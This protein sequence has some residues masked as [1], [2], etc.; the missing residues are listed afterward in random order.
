MMVRR[1]TD[2]LRSLLRRKHWAAPLLRRAAMESLEDRQLMADVGAG[3][4]ANY[5]SDGNF[6][7][8][9]A[10]RTDSTIDFNWGT[11]SPATGVPAEGFSARWTGQI[12]APTSGN[13]KLT[14]D[15]AGGIKVTIGGKSVIDDSKFHSRHSVNGSFA[16]QAG[17]FYDVQVEYQ[18][19]GAATARLLWTPP[20][21][22][23]Q[24]IPQEDLYRLGTGWLSSG[25]LSS[26]LT[27][28]ETRAVTGGS[29]TSNGD[30]FTLSSGFGGVDLRSASAISDADLGQFAY[31]TM[32]QDGQ[33]VL[34]VDSVTNG[35]HANIVFRKSLDT[36][37]PFVDLS[38]ANGHASVQ[39]RLNQ[40][41]SIQS[42]TL[43][44][45]SGPTYVKL[46]RDADSFAGYVSKT[47]AEEDWT[48]VG[49]AGVPMDTFAQVG[50]QVAGAGTT[51]AIVSDV[52]VGTSLAL[53]GNLTKVYASS[54]DRPFVDLIK[55]T[56]QFQY[57]T[58]RPC[59]V[60]SNGMPTIGD[61][62]AAVAGGGHIPGGRYTVT[63]TGP[64]SAQ[65]VS[66]RSGVKV[67]RASIDSHGNQVWY[68][69][70]PNNQNMVGLRWLHMGNWGRNLRVLQPGY[71]PTNTPMYTAR[72]L[73][74]LRSLHPASLRFMDWLATNE[75]TDSN[76]SERTQPVSADWADRGVS[77]EAAIELC[78]QVGSNLYANVP[79]RASDDYVR[80]L[81]NL[82]KSKLRPDLNVYLEQGN[83]VWATNF[84]NG[85]WNMGQALAEVKAAKRA[86][87]ESN[88]NYDHLKVN[89]AQTSPTAG[90]AAIWGLR[91]TAR[92]AKQIGDIFKSVFGG[93]SL[94]TRVRIIVAAQ[95]G[96]LYT[97][98]VMLKY[99]N[100]NYGRPGNYIYAMAGAPYF[101]MGQYNDKIVNGK[102]TTLN[103]N[104]SVNQLIGGMQLSAGSYT[105]IKKFSTFWSHGTPF[106]VRLAMYE[107]GH[108]TFGPF[109]IAAKAK[110]TLDSRMKSM[111]K[112]YLLAF[113][114]QGGASFNYYTLGSNE[115][116][117]HFGTWA[118]TTDPNNVN[119]PKA[120]A[121]REIRGGV[122]VANVLASAGVF[123]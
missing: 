91:R 41:G 59:P 8:L 26:S 84:V 111:M 69:D 36:G 55:L 66:M 100:A 19:R 74:F 31:K 40:G 21:K 48:L 94:N 77:W 75:T 17:E 37:A 92:R 60:D 30:T 79:A 112:N 44:N 54:S 99:L 61:F 107:G 98:D 45:V 65:V 71:S 119:T 1:V 118:I 29:L 76:W 78:N 109:N 96:N 13:Y 83:E 9:A 113:F 121:F 89:M 80:Q 12:S 14:A 50:F 85:P 117:S 70:V 105:K 101:T 5:Y 42:S 3:L 18:D 53:G 15:S 25:W 122:G 35:G 38:I 63:F 104:A 64:S 68:A 22:A 103:K 62:Q 4:V 97:F 88:L 6:Q 93:N 32:R 58:G 67:T 90:N 86:G 108:D 115:Y 10:A 46:T 73:G 56:D 116:D 47:G 82:I 39:Y 81:A 49:T 106:G 43:T 34:R 114:A 20:G 2:R 27:S 51:R 52:R 57:V 7:N 87:H 11:G 33:I 23:K 24:V 102:W 110:A 16:F 123:A 28:N 120:Q 72:Y 95:I